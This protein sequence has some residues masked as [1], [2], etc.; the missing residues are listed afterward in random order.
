MIREVFSCSSFFKDPTV[1]GGKQRNV[2][3]V[4]GSVRI[5]VKIES[6]KELEDSL[7]TNMTRYSLN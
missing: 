3:A 7:R 1:A 5:Q 4:E 2:M 6:V